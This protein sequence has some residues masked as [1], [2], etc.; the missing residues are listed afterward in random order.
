MRS[1][2][3]S[4]EHPS[5]GSGVT[6]G[7]SDTERRGETR[8][9]RW[10][11]GLR[12]P[13]FVLGNAVKVAWSVTQRRKPRPPPTLQALFL[14][15]HFSSPFS[16][17]YRW[18]MTGIEGESC[19]KSACDRCARRPGTP[20]ARRVQICYCHCWLEPPQLPPH[21]LPGPIQLALPPPYRAFCLKLDR[22]F[23]SSPL[24]RRIVPYLKSGK[25][26]LSACK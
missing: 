26:R 12:C 19:A 4:G 16:E 14:S 3:R 5:C 18:V 10:A 21:P 25:S 6:P 23:G 13:L 9:E 24:C 11:T 1:C 17:L 2:A 20:P 7:S 22:D 15:C 8:S